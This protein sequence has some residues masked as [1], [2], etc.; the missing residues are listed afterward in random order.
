VAALLDAA[1]SGF[2]DRGF[3]GAT[4]T[5]IAARAGA[6]IGLLYQFSRPRSFWLRP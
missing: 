4:M 2:A 6:S 5:E 1:G 3:D